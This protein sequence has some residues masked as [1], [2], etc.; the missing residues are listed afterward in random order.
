MPLSDADR[1]FLSNEWRW[2]EASDAAVQARHPGAGEEEYGTAFIDALG[3]AIALDVIKLATNSANRIRVVT[4]QGIVDLS[5]KGRPPMIRLFHDRFGE[6][7]VTGKLLM[8]EAAVIDYGLERT[9]FT[10]SGV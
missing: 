2:L 3:A 6:D 7:A 5:F 10:V 4:V 9:T 1:A 8:V